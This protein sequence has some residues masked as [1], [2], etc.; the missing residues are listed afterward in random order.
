MRNAFFS[1]ISIYALLH[2][3]FYSSAYAYTYVV[4]PNDNLSHNVAGVLIPGPVWGAKGSLAKVLRLNPSIKDPHRLNPGQVI[5]LG[6]LISSQARADATVQNST[7]ASVT[8]AL[9][10]VPASPSVATSSTANPPP[11]R[12]PAEVTSSPET[13][14][15]PM[16]QNTAKDDDDGSATS[17]TLTPFLAM[18]TLSSKDISN[19]TP[20]SVS[21]NFY[22]GASG[23]FNQVLSDTLQTHLGAKL[24]YISFEAPIETSSSVTGG[25][26]FLTTFDLGVDA[27]LGSRFHLGV[28]LDLEKDLFV[29]SVS[30]NNVTV[31][32]IQ[33]PSLGAA[34]AYDLLK[35]NAFNLSITGVYEEKFGA[36]TDVYS[37]QTGQRFGG[38]LGVTKRNHGEDRYAV[39][40]G[41]FRRNQNTSV[42]T[43]SETS[44]EGSLQIFF[45]DSSAKKSDGIPK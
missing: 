29:R 12:A 16:N 24:S 4:K 22:A 17:W 33:I 2:F 23:Q 27:K 18:T 21:S 9:A 11:V 14:L 41:A 8:Q 43:Q 37:V 44:Y 32:A 36:T 5:E 10:C 35:R 42:T 13:A 38:K 25:S 20:A 30:T 34:I 28:S 19:G 6:D 26:K 1:I 31:D 40:L 39:I 45:P 7:G 15:A 3:E